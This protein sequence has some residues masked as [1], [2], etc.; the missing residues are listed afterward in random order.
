[1]L[2]CNTVQILYQ[3]LKNESVLRAILHVYSGLGHVATKFLC[4][5]SYFFFF[6]PN[7]W[8][9]VFAVVNSF[10]LEYICENVD[11]FVYCFKV[12]NVLFGFF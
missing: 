6:P 7:N 5:K 9:K 12:V 2:L 10:C 3:H 4:P 11:S 8:L 1:M